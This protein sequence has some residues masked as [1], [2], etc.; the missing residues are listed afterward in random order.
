MIIKTLAALILL[1]ED[2][3]LHGWRLLCWILGFAGLWLFDLGANIPVFLLFAGGAGY[4]AWHDLYHIR[5]PQEHAILRRLEQD[6]GL[7]HRPFSALSD[8]PVNTSEDHPLW[9]AHRTALNRLLLKCRAPRPKALLT[10]KDPYALRLLASLLFISGL[11][12]A[13]P[14][15]LERLKTGLM[16]FSWPARTAETAQTTRALWIIPPAYT[17]LGPLPLQDPTAES[18]AIPEGSTIKI[19]LSHTAPAF[20]GKPFLYVDTIGFPLTVA[21]DGTALMARTLS[22]GHRLTLS[23]NFFHKT[24]WAYHLIPDTAPTL[25]QDKPP[26]VSGQGALTFPLTLKDDY[27]VKTL[28][29]HMTLAQ[30]MEKEPLGAPVM[31]S[32]TVMSAPDTPLS[33]SPVFDLAGHPWAGLPALIT[34]TATDEAGHATHSLPIPL[35]L[36]ER[37]FHNPLAKNLIEIRKSLIRDPTASYN[38]SATVLEML[39]EEN[40]PLLDRMTRMAFR[41]AASRLFYNAPSRQTSASL[42]P[43]LWKTALHL[44]DGSLS[45]SAEA[46][47][48]AEKALEDA[49]GNPQTTPE[50]LAGLMDTLRQ[51]LAEYLSAASEEMQKR[52]QHGTLPESLPAEL[53]AQTLQTSDL[54]DLL[55]KMEADLLSGDKNAARDMLSRLQRLTEALN[56]DHDHTLPKDIQQML[57]GHNVLKELIARQESLRDNSVEQAKIIDM[58]SEMGQLDSTGR[59]PPPFVKTQ[60][61]A[62]AQQ[63]L[64]TEL[65]TLAKTLTPPPE[66]MAP[67]SRA[68]GEAVQPLKNARP[69]QARPLQEDALTN[70]KESQSRLSQALAQRMKDLTGL[71]FGGMMDGAGGRDPLGR[72]LAQDQNADVT[73][74]DEAE[75]NRIREI[76]EEIRRRAADQT[77]PPEELDYYRRLLKRF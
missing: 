63:I 61:Q 5:L 38:V 13:G 27:G 23:E 55:D 43:L 67:A 39:L 45:L 17:R 3:T 2:L 64:Q 36:P 18:L 56:P 46:L 72:P 77:L 26:Q 69:D 16:P 50:Q 28:T 15:A 14:Q 10:R 74:P 54:A 4:F 60:E 33:F 65:D 31:D 30:S 76:V 73:I 57:E 9:K 62:K 1:L 6:S 19:F 34:L 44:E 37:P 32:R 41:S 21:P 8:T 42:A 49:L 7:P 12:V 66:N 71:S 59:T 29:L 70:L 40:A 51:K 47:Q 22:E 24:T 58:L 68:M 48:K 35:T 25:T 20:L 52:A 75:A 53:L 11:M